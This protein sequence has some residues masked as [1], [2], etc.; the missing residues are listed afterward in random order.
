MFK[1]S[2]SEYDEM[3]VTEEILLGLL[4]GPTENDITVE[5]APVELEWDFGPAQNY[6]TMS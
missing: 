3:V 1:L 5:D 6:E 2:E 4:N